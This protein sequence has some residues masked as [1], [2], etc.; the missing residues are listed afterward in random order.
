MLI[1]Y[2]SLLD[3][4]RRFELSSDP[5]ADTIVAENDENQNIIEEEKCREY[6]Q[7]IFE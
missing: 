5:A 2:K 3:F 1:N 7:D 6:I 4:D